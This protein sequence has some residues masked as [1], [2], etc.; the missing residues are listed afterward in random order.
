MVGACAIGQTWYGKGLR[1][2]AITRQEIRILNTEESESVIKYKY[3]FEYWHIQN[4][5]TG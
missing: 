4:S 1:Y 3:A 2:K 5:H